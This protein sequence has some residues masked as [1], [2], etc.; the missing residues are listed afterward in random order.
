MADP[1]NSRLGGGQAKN[2]FGGNPGVYQGT[3]VDVGL[4]YTAIIFG[5]ELT[6]ALD[7]GVFIPG[8]ALNDAGGNTVIDPVYGARVTLQY[9]L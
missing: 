7:A 6:M 3:E 9:R 2:A 8:D 5:S 4:R 1:L